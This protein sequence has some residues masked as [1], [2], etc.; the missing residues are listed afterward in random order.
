[1]VNETYL[2]RCREAKLQIEKNISA[3]KT[4]TLSPK[5]LGKCV[6][7]LMEFGMLLIFMLWRK[8]IPDSHEKAFSCLGQSCYQLISKK[9]YI[10]AKNVLQFCLFKQKPT[11][12]DN[13]HRMMVINLANAY[14]KLKIEAECEKVLANFDWSATKDE[15][16]LCIAS[17]RRDTE[18]VVALMP[19]TAASNAITGNDFREWPVL[20]WVRDD[21]KVQE[22]FERV[23]GEPMR[24]EVSSASD[25]ASSVGPKVPEPEINDSTDT[26][27]A[28]RH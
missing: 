15:F 23:Y 27:G 10:A 18:R 22:T 13:I 26:V 21:P 14:K 11:C 28:T 17:L 12:S 6:N 20:D 16:Q 7:I 3:G 4:L 1:V 5:Y 2:E 19:G 9:R 8:H 25:M 24:T